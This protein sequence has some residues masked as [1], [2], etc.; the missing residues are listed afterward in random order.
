M[1]SHSNAPPTPSL[2]DKIKELSQSR[3]KTRATKKLT[4]EELD[5]WKPIQRKEGAFQ[6]L[7][8]PSGTPTWT[9]TKFNAHTP[10]LEIFLSQFPVQDVYRL[11]F[12]RN[13]CPPTFAQYMQYIAIRIRIQAIQK[14]PKESEQ[15]RNPQR[16]SFAKAIQHFEDLGFAGI[17]KIEE[18]HRQFY[19]LEPKDELIVNKHLQSIVHQL[20]GIPH[21]RSTFTHS[22]L[23]FVSGDEKL[24]QFSGR[25]GWTRKKASTKCGI[26]YYTL[27]AKL[28]HNLPIQI[29][30]RPH[31]GPTCVDEIIRDWNEV[32]LSLKSPWTILAFDAYYTSRASLNELDLTKTLFIAGLQK[33]RFLEEA[34]AVD[35]AV[36]KPGEYCAIY[37]QEK[38]HLFVC[39]Y[40]PISRIAKKFSTTNAFKFV[41]NA[42]EMANLIPCH[43]WFKFCF[44]LCDRFN[45]GFN[46][47]T[48][49]H[50]P[51]GGGD[52]DGQAK[53]RVDFVFSSILQ[54]AFNCW[55]NAN[56]DTRAF[57]SFQTFCLMLAEECAVYSM[58]LLIAI[59]LT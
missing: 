17:N 8:P 28:R 20:G 44:S 7:C 15:L 30:L 33:G 42:V 4:Q 5:G 46:D 36:K 37:H 49:P 57:T 43:D 22:C 35:D 1:I 9:T 40:D 26:W 27:C 53:R 39:A 11:M 55:R 21:C 52:D 3:T 32:I 19:F 23:D 31:A 41:P 29:Y 58:H 12:G 45:R 38:N 50:R 48:W 24:W 2:F 54:N 14:K 18:I 6:L 13:L 25:F 16:K 47:R 56:W 59:S 51:G 34:T 10:P